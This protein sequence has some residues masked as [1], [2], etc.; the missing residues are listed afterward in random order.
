MPVVEVAPWASPK[1]GNLADGRDRDAALK[2]K[3]ASPL[4]ALGA[5][6]QAMMY[7]S[8]K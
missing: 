2:G 6:A 7:D 1:S 3:Q 4:P 5:Y 8:N